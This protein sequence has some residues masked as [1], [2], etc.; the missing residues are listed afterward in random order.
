MS[1]AIGAPTTPSNMKKVNSVGA[2]MWEIS[3]AGMTRGGST[4]WW[5]SAAQAVKSDEMAYECDPKLGSPSGV[6]CSA[7][8]WSQL[9][10][11]SVTPHSDTVTLGPGAVQFLHSNT[12][13]LAISA[14]Q[15]VVLNW[16]QIRAATDALINLCVQHPFLPSTGGRAYYAPPN[17]SRS[18][19]KRQNKVT[20]LNA[21]PPPASI[22]MFQQQA[23]WTNPT[24]ELASCTWDA[25]S[26]GVAISTC[27]NG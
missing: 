7:I 10:P 22:I 8:E 25:I 3:A 21:L 5:I 17:R 9:G 20:G 2:K 1:G 4:T 11:A 16:D 18:R 13:Y 15:H 19:R 14:V 27:K 23:P 24:V 26:H 12:C 6:D